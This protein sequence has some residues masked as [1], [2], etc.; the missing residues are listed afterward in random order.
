MTTYRSNLSIKQITENYPL[1]SADL[2]NFIS[3]YIRYPAPVNMSY[4]L[5]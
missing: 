3:R 2:L 5:T 4:T 1:L